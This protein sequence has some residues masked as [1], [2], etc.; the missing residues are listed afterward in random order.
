MPPELIPAPIADRE[1]SATQI[2]FVILLLLLQVL[3]VV[4]V[5]WWWKRRQAKVSQALEDES[6]QTKRRCRASGRLA[7]CELVPFDDADFS[8]IDDGGDDSVDQSD[9]RADA[10]RSKRRDRPRRH[11]RRSRRSAPE[12]ESP[13]GLPSA[14][15]YGAALQDDFLDDFDLD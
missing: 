10:R 8:T 5:L 12:A 1:G 11:G 15:F 9:M 14:G 13:N 4:P 6:P 3:V 7:V 2:G